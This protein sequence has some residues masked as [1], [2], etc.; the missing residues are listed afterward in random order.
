MAVKE[1]IFSEEMEKEREELLQE[2]ILI[3]SLSHPRTVRMVGAILGGGV[4]GR[5]GEEY[6]SLVM[7][8][9]DCGWDKIVY[10]PEN[11]PLTWKQRLQ[12]LA[13]V[14]EGKQRVWR[15]KSFRFFNEFFFFF[16]GMSIIHE[17][18]IT[19]RDLKSA[20]VLVCQLFYPNSFYNFII[21]IF[22][23]VRIRKGRVQE[24]IIDAKVSDFNM[25]CVLMDAKR[26]QTWPPYFLAPEIMSG[27]PARFELNFLKKGFKKLNPLL[28]FLVDVYSFGVLAYETV[29]RQLLFA[30][31]VQHR[32]DEKKVREAV[33]EGKRPHVVDAYP[34]EKTPPEV[35]FLDHF[36]S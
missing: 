30:D 34:F 35:A 23:Q 11:Y 1:Y 19:H 33:K 22:T 14:A 16:Q 25:S 9:M 28:S 32:F 17:A 5:G 10:N 36:L 27:N 24:F 4:R 13:H 7:E 26:M 3:S 31:M 8:A 15:V 6:H 29:A 20:N 18:G 2:L 12:V 21:H